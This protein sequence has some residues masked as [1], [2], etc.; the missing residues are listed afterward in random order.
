MVLIPE[1]LPAGALVLRRWHTDDAPAIAAAVTASLEHLRPWMAW[2]AAEPLPLEERR[3]LIDAWRNAPNHTE[4]V[5]GM[6]RDGELVGGCGLHARSSA[7]GREI[8]YWVHAQHVRHGYASAAAR[9][10]TDYAFTVPGVT[11]VEIHHDRTN[12]ASAGIPRKLGFR[13]IGERS[14][15]PLAPAETGVEWI[16]RTERDAWLRG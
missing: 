14:K 9:A 8:G 13:F 15:T 16:W 5:F 7:D 10:L 2:I 3:R 6:F 1:E 4:L 12:T 11:W